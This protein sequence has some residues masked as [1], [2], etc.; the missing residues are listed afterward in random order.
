[1]KRIT[2]LC[3]L[4]VAL[5]QMSFAANFSV[6][7]LGNTPTAKTTNTTS[8][9]PRIS[10][11]E[12]LDAA[13]HNT[14]ATRK[15]QSKHHLKRAL[16]KEFKAQQGESGKSQI[17]AFLLCFFF[18]VL[19]IHRFY[20]GYTIVGVLYL[21]TFGLLGFG[22]FIDLILLIFPNGLRPKGYSSY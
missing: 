22:A 11:K 14:K 9:P 21:F 2:V 19:G 10:T 13:R 12:G 4:L 1:M 16:K 18:G 8:A 5:S 20:L 7:P 17:A 15:S 3:C 6:S